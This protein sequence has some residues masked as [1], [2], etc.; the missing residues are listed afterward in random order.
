MF[1]AKAIG[2]VVR[3]DAYV[4]STPADA[5]DSNYLVTIKDANSDKVLL[6]EVSSGDYTLPASSCKTFIITLQTTLLM[7]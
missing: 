4:T 6:A 3:G 2:F 7:A 1:T 5:P